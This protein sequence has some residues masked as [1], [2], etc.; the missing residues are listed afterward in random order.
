[1]LVSCHVFPTTIS[2]HE[3]RM[4]RAGRATIDM[5]SG[6]DRMCSPAFRVSLVFFCVLT[7]GALAQTDSSG[8]VIAGSVIDAGTNSPIRRA[9]ITL[10]TV[11]AQPQDAVAWTDANG[12]F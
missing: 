10:S 1:M 2:R 7:I 5:S 8:G 9:I 6:D 12:R 4:R 3:D 11:E